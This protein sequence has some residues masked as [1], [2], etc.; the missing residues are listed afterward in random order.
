MAKRKRSMNFKIYI[1]N[2]IKNRRKEMG[3]K[4]QKALAAAMGVD[5][6]RI[7]RWESGQNIPDSHLRKTLC[8][9]LKVDN[10]F[11]ETI[12]NYFDEPSHTKSES[13]AIAFLVTTM[14]G[15]ASAELSALANSARSIL[16][17]RPPKGRG[18]AKT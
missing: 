11:F 1:G 6:T 8:R 17:N 7:S 12:H 14:A 10:Q 3:F 13:E 2:K 16:R 4:N 9:L 18:I 5:E 15:M